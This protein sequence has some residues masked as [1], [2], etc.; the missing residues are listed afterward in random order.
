MEI[1]DGDPQVKKILME[2]DFDEDPLSPLY[3]GGFDGDPYVKEI[4]MQ[5]LV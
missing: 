5:I 1:L 4:F 2:G 3:K